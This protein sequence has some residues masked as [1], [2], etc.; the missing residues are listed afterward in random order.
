M[1]TPS[2]FTIPRHVM[3]RQVGDETVILDLSNGTYFG[4]EPVGTRIWQLLTEG[5]SLANISSAMV[6]EFDVTLDVVQADTQRLVNDLL[7]RGL[8]VSSD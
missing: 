1:N 7:S 6:E 5:Q 8:L 2:M 4:L 3:A